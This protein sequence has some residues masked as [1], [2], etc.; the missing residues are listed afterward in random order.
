MK[1]QYSC[2]VSWYVKFPATQCDIPFLF[3]ITT[4]I[5]SARGHYF[6]NDFVTQQRYNN[7]QT[8]KNIY[9]FPSTIII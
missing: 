9:F 4:F 7:E 2:D 5:Q 1:A 3:C 8:V 6:V